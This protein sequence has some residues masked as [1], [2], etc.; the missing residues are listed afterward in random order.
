VVKL[1]D[2]GVVW[3]AEPERASIQAAGGEHHLADIA[4]RSCPLCGA[5]NRSHLTSK[6]KIVPDA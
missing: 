3:P 4:S 5:G 6:V 1:E 2:H